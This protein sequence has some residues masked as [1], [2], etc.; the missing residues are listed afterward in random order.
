MMRNH[1]RK[2]IRDTSVY[3][4]DNNVQDCT[5]HIKDDYFNY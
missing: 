3:H 4:P 5:E 2:K 1:H